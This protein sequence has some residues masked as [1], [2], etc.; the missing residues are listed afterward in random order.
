MIGKYK[1]K[2]DDDLSIVRRLI[3]LSIDTKILVYTWKRMGSLKDIEERY[4]NQHIFGHWFITGFHPECNRIATTVTKGW[5]RIHEFQEI[6][7]DEFIKILG[8]VK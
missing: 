3:K 1:I 5:Y 8:E 7:V 2:F 4:G 6:T